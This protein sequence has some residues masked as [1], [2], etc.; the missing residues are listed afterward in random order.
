MDTSAD[1]LDAFFTSDSLVHDLQARNSVASNDHVSVDSDERVQRQVRRQT[2][3]L[4]GR[5]HTAKKANKNFKSGLHCSGDNA[6]RHI[7]GWF[8]QYCF[9]ITEGQLLEYK[10]LSPLHFMVAFLGYL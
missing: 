2:E 9:N 6:V 4:Q 8:Y 5:Y 3:K 7:I 1:L 10:E